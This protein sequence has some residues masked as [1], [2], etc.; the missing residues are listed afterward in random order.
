MPGKSVYK[1]S[2]IIAVARMNHQTCGLI[3]HQHRIILIYNVERNILGYDFT[4]VARAIHHHRNH[5]V[6][7]YPIVRLYGLAVGEDTTGLGSLLNPV[8]RCPLHVVD[9]K[10]VDA[11][12]LLPLVGH[13][14]EMLV[15][16][17]S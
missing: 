10:L 1:R 8:A 17:P 12:K 4:F 13:K 11:Q 2:G 5:V 16:L 3:D 14:A 9:Q 7:L 15:H 6:G